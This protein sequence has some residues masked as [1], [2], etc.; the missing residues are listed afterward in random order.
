MKGCAARR[1]GTVKRRI[2]AALGPVALAALAAAAVARAEP[3]TLPRTEIR[4][5]ESKENGVGYAI[6]VSLPPSYGDGEAR[7]P[8]IYLL[9]ADYSFAIAKNVTEHLSDR[10]DLPETLLVGIAYAGP[11]RYRLNRTRDY[12]PTRVLELGPGLRSQEQHQAQAVSGGAEAFSR[13]LA[14]ELVPF[15]DREYRTVPGDRTLVGHSYG[16]LFGAWVLFTSPELFSRYLLVSPSLWYDDHAILGLEERFARTGAAL[17]ARVFLTVGSREHNRYRNMVEDL[18]TLAARMRGRGYRGLD[19]E[20]EVF[21]DETHNSVF[22]AGLT[23]GVRF[24]FAEPVRAAASRGEPPESEE[25]AASP[26]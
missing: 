3:V 11:L 18:E 25:M 15:I 19:L 17:P 5:L 21:D 20:T 24:L 16:G 13:F 12:T 2:V 22:A 8:V 10:G 14:R 1:G 23:R 7:Y 6:Y 9:D 4:S 26:P